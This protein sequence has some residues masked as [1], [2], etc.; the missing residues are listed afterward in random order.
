MK[1][2]LKEKILNAKKKGSRVEREIKKIFEESGFSVVRS[3]GSIGA[4][5][6]QVEKIGSVQVK[7]RK[8]FAVLNMF[9][10]A[11]KLVIKADRK[12]AYIVMPLKAY[13]EEILK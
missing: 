3:A 13:L 8:S 1:E 6:L 7:A 5:D 12:E 10:G 4:A 2:K 11:D 9:D